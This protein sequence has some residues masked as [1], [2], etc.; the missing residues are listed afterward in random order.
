MELLDTITE[1]P[2][3]IAVS[4]SNELFI[5]VGIYSKAN[6]KFL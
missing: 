2:F 3:G 1:N 5:D 4:S 6:L